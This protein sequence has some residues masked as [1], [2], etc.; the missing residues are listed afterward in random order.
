MG[1]Q[2]GRRCQLTPDARTRR[3][4]PALG[5]C[6]QLLVGP[7]ARHGS[8]S[9]GTTGFRGFGGRRGR[10]ATWWARV[11]V[12]VRPVD[13]A[14]RRARRTVAARPGA[15]HVARTFTVV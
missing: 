5:Q 10:G 12:E 15:H 6:D 9:A 13:G 2:P 7:E 1:Q 14:P 4:E 3:D 8:L 11:A